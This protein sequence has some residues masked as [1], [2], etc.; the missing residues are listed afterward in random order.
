MSSQDNSII[1]ILFIFY[2]MIVVA[3]FVFSM[4]QFKNTP[5]HGFVVGLFFNLMIIGVFMSFGSR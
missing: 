2:L 3:I 5:A 1:G 4:I